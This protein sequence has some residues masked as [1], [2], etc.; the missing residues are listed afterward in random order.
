MNEG[1]TQVYADGQGRCPSWCKPGPAILTKSST[2]I[3]GYNPCIV[4]AKV[5]ECQILNLH[6]HKIDH[7]GSMSK[8]QVLSYFSRNGYSSN[9]G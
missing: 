7:S 2:T 1:Q 8:E 5:V 3:N 9:N 6:D 4:S